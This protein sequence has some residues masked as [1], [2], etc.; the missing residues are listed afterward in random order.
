MQ[1]LMTL[2][3]SKGI[4]DDRMDVKEREREEMGKREEV[5]IPYLTESRWRDDVHTDI[6]VCF[7]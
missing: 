6:Y 4:V 3:K 1:I 7:L 5:P 2:G